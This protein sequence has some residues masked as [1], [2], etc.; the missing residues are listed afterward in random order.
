[1]KYL[2]IL[3]SVLLLFSCK[4]TGENLVLKQGQV[5]EN[6]DL[7]IEAVEL[8]DSRCP[9]G[10]NCIWEGYPE[11][12]IKVTKGDSINHLSLGGYTTYDTIMFDYQIALIDITPNPEIEGEVKAYKRKA[13]FTLKKL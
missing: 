12:Y 11:A 5:G 10:T 2:V 13:H 7:T 3:S 4:K 6:G 9:K 8:S 1:M